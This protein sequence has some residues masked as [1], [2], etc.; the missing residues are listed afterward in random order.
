MI[1]P[2]IAMVFPMRAAWLIVA[3]V[4]GGDVALVALLRLALDLPRTLELLISAIGPRGAL[5]LLEFTLEAWRGLGTPG[6]HALRPFGA[7]RRADFMT[8]FTGGSMACFVL[9]RLSFL[10]HCRHRHSRR[11]QNSY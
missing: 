1:P 10:R 8:R 3:V 11:K 2:G 6:L 7:P 4:R 5:E 9:M